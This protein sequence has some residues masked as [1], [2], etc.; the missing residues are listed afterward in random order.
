MPLS[1]YASYDATQFRLFCI[2]CAGGGASCY[3]GWIRAL[4]PRIQVIPVQ[5]PGREGR[6]LEPPLESIAAMVEQLSVE[7]EPLLDHPF[8]LFGHS[9]GALIAFE[10]ARYLRRTR[11]A[12]LRRL[13]IGGL[14]S[15]QLLNRKKI[16]ANPT[17]A[18]LLRRLHKLGGIPAPIRQSGEFMNLFL[19]TLRADLRAAASYSFRQEEP[20]PCPL[21]AYGGWEDDEVN[22]DELVAWCT[23][24][25]G[26]FNLRMFPGGH[27]FVR[28]ATPSV[29]RAIGDD[30]GEESGRLD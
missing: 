28:T 11:A 1:A 25:K 21:S 12:Q 30:L 8:A 13:I 27:F 22:R 15:P 3:A 9:N 17:D 19:A 23:L 10:L 6:V 18:Q 29:L 16:D 5:L 14:C 4:G 2:P 24:T 20:L 26:A 7:L